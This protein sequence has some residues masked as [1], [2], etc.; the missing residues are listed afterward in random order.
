MRVAGPCARA[1][2]RNAESARA[3]ATDRPTERASECARERACERARARARAPQIGAPGPQSVART[4][5]RA[6]VV[7]RRAL[8]HP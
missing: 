7:P 8:V 3:R 6:R 2:Q 5:A 1:A 4:R